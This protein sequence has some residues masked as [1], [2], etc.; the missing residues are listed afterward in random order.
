MQL[1][2]TQQYVILSKLAYC[3]DLIRSSCFELQPDVK[4]AMPLAF[5]CAKF[6]YERNDVEVNKSLTSFR[7]K[8]AAHFL[9]PGAT[10]IDQ[11][12]LNK[13]NAM[14]NGIGDLSKLF[15]GDPVMVKSLTLERFSANQDLTQYV[16]PVAKFSK[17]IAKQ[18]LLDWHS[19]AQKVNTMNSDQVKNVLSENIDRILP[20]SENSYV[21]L[22]QSSARSR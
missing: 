13:I 2:E 11:D 14:V 8:V 3:M 10:S 22:S 21:S 15:D 19:L 16:R 12:Q 17:Q 4:L 9:E 6:A 18:F 1:N 5:N 20:D 7:N